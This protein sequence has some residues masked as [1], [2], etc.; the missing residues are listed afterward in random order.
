L[1]PNR[2]YLNRGNHEDLSLNLSRHFDPN[3]KKDTELKFNKYGSNFFNQSQRLFRRLPLATIVENSVG[4][5]CFVAHGGLSSRLDLNFISSPQFERFGFPSITI[6]NDDSPMRR[7]TAEQF[8][9]LLW[10]DPIT[11]SPKTGCYPN[12]HRG[13]GWL[14]GEDVSTE[15]CKKNRFNC[16]IR[17]HE[18][19][20]AGITQDHPHCFTIFSSS[21][22]CSGNNQAAVLILNANE[23]KLA[24]HRFRTDPYAQKDY[25]QQKDFLINS[26]KSFLNKEAN[27]L[28]RKFYQLDQGNTNWLNTSIWA[29]TL[30]QHI[31]EKYGNNIDPIH[32]ITLKDYLCPCNDQNNTVNYTLMFKN[33]NGSQEDMQVLEFLESLFYIID[34]DGNGSISKKECDEAILFMNKTLGTNYSSN[35]LNEID[36][37]RDG[38]LSIVEFKLGFC[39]AFNLG[40]HF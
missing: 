34:T 27:V 16:V 33:Q 23:T 32:F 5:R 22:Y 38:V 8:T 10:S 25:S 15:F 20:D 7:K 21:N 39:K 17:S 37:N 28:V 14:F 26:F 12:N 29:S 9:D 4:F 24:H 3:F 13:I 30:S 11:S 36:Q 18:C 31:L 2:V 1:Y 35:F 6:K 19:R 40:E